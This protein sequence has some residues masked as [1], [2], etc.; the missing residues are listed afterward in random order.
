MPVVLTPTTP[1]VVTEQKI[2]IFLRDYALDVLPGGQG[3][4]ILDTVQ[5][6]DEELDNSIE[7][8]VSAFNGMTP[9][10][11]YTR[12]NFPNEYLLLIGASRFLMMSEGFHQLRNQISAQDGDVS[13]SGIYEKANAYVALAQALRDEWQQMA[14]AIKNQMNMES[15]YGFVGSGYSYIGRRG[16]YL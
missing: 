5:F 6:T 8:A 10:G 7:M 3:N 15:A 13:P 11:S 2:R 1:F 9:I 16:R 12:E 4:I 14:R